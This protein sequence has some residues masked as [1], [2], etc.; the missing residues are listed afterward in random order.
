MRARKGTLLALWLLCLIFGQL[1]EKVV[2]YDD[3]PN[4]DLSTIDE[5]DPGNGEY[6]STVDEEDPG[7]EEE[8][9]TTEDHENEGYEEPSED[10]EEEFEEEA[11]ELALWEWYLIVGAGVFVL[12]FGCVFGSFLEVKYKEWRANNG[13]ED[14]DD[15][16]H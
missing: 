14:D 16:H 3:I 12:L 4:E 15:D 10:P 9:P 5:E 13:Y 8:E 1:F 7:N 2:A 6:D 11:E